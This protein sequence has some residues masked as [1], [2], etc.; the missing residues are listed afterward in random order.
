ME[1]REF[2]IRSIANL[3]TFNALF[4]GRLMVAL[5][6]TEALSDEAVEKLLQLL[7]QD[8][9]VLDGA[10]DQEAAT[11]LLAS[12]RNLLAARRGGSGRSRDA[13]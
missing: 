6:S 7:D 3:W 13:G 2:I 10:D 9:E 5:R 4:I 12:V 1:D 8:A 11:A